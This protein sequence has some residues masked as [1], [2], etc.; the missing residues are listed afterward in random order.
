MFQMSRHLSLQ[1]QIHDFSNVF[2][3][4]IFLSVGLVCSLSVLLFY[5]VIRQGSA[6]SA[7]YAPV[8]PTALIVIEL[9]MEIYILFSLLPAG[10]L[11]H[12]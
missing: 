5:G 10:C 12:L 3:P 1:H 6:L 7:V 9:H 11:W 4:F 2:G 8:I